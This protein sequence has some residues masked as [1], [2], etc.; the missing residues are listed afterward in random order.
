[1]KCPALPS[2]PCCSLRDGATDLRRPRQD[3]RTQRD[4]E[5][6]WENHYS[7]AVERRVAVGNHLRAGEPPVSPSRSQVT[8]G[9]HR[10]ECP[11]SVGAAWQASPGRSR[12]RH[13]ET[14]GHR[15]RLPRRTEGEGCLVAAEG[16]CTNMHADPAQRQ[17]PDAPRV[18]GHSANSWPV[19]FKNV[20]AVR[21]TGK[22][23]N[24]SQRQ[25]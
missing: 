1:M 11:A 15:G 20:A 5:R 16:H 13:D 2:A 19:S 17:T 24:H 23:R 3:R 9:P 18:K 10:D 8:W 25:G 12:H 21:H 6:G 14:D 4:N 7:Q 22:T